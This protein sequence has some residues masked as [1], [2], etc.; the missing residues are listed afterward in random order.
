M[1]ILAAY[2]IVSIL[3]KLG[4]LAFLK[5]PLLVLMAI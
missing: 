5:L 3:E 2:C 1:N 4:I